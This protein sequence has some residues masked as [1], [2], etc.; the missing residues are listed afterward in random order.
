[1]KAIGKYQIIDEIGTGAAGTTYRVRDT[2][3]ERE[4]AL[5]ILLSSPA[6]SPET[7]DQF[8]RGLAQYTDLRHPNIAKVHDLGEA[9]GALYIASELLNGIDLRRH[10][11]ERRVLPL[12]DKLE[13]IASI[14][15]A[16]TVPH[17]KGIAHG[18]LKPANIFIVAGKYARILDFGSG[19]WLEVIMA[20]GVKPPAILPNY[21]APEQIMGDPSD[22]RSDIFSVAMILYE[23]LTGRYPF[24]VD[25]NLIPRE[26]MHS[27]PAPLRKLDSQIPEELEQLVARA[28]TKNREQRLQSAGEFATALNNIAQ[29]VRDSR[30]APEPAAPVF[31]APVVTPPP[32]V[33]KPAPTTTIMLIPKAPAVVASIPAP[34]QPPATVPVAAPLA[35]APAGPPPVTP[36]P[37]LEAIK[38][39]SQG[40][41]KKPIPGINAALLRKRMIPIAIAALLAIGLF[42]TLLSRQSSQAS[43]SKSEAPAIQPEI[44]NPPAPAPAAT[45]SVPVQSVDVAPPQPAPQP[46]AGSRVI[47]VKPAPE[48]ILRGQVKSLWEAGKYS[49]AMRLVDAIL[50]ENPDQAEARA[51]K[52]KIRAA[53][54]AEAAIK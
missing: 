33:E 32:V 12:E 23:L 9:D 17:S 14:A 10:F 54:D 43:E 6:A 3:G 37:A 46:S 21:L 24:Q 15:D 42:G 39:A 7:K 47:E 19:K 16:L 31:A 29:R 25:A 49:Q 52:K 26:I 48:T 50:D 40:P 20:S 51:W 5:K 41:P 35:S 36:Q 38:T 44:V 11:E 30:T 1:M 4:L 27:E 34:A 45:I 22:A 18:D 13:F 2:A 53:Q 28:L 8:C